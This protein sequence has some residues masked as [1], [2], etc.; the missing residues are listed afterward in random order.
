MKTNQQFTDKD[1]NIYTLECTIYNNYFFNVKYTNGEVGI[2]SV[3]K[4]HIESLNLK[5]I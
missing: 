4:Q 1:G 5:Q 2:K 3:R